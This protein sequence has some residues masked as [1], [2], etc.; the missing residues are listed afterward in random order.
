MNRSLPRRGE[1]G[2]C[3]QQVL[4]L[5]VRD[6][7]SPGDEHMMP[8]GGICGGSLQQGLSSSE[9]EIMEQKGLGPGWQ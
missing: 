3:G 6:G 7:V 9:L 1:E 8:G 2:C 5:G 4:A